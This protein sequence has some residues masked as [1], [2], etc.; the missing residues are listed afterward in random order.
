MGGGT[1]LVLHYWLEHLCGWPPEGDK[2][3]ASTCSHQGHWYLEAGWAGRDAICWPHTHFIIWFITYIG[4]AHCHILCTYL[5]HAYL[6]KLCCNIWCTD[7]YINILN[8][9]SFGH[10]SFYHCLMARHYSLFYLPCLA[11]RLSNLLEVIFSHYIVN[12][13][14]IILKSFLV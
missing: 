2:Y 6:L 7:I 11:C 12:K 13:F 14:C 8:L 3:R 10:E 9:S 5:L 1:A 4:F